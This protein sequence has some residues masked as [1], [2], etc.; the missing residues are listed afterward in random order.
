MSAPSLE[1]ANIALALTESTRIIDSSSRLCRV[2]KSF[3]TSL[4][5]VC[6]CIFWSMH[7]R[8]H[9]PCTWYIADLQRIS[10]F[11]SAI[12]ILF[13]DRFRFILLLLFIAWAHPPPALALIYLSKLHYC[14]ILIAT[15]FHPRRSVIHWP[16]FILFWCLFSFSTLLSFIL[17]LRK[18]TAWIIRLISFS[19]LCWSIHLHIANLTWLDLTWLDTSSLLTLETGLAFHS[20]WFWSF[21]FFFFFLYMFYFCKISCHFVTLVHCLL[22]FCVF[23]QSRNL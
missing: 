10:N 22:L 20:L 9:S 15:E 3:S 19:F 1:R 7:H 13:C 14:I 11:I 8:F 5:C 18:P 4:L 2:L 16:S 23:W 17:C 21:L 12:S 6:A